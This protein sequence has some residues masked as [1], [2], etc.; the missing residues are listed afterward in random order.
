MPTKA[1][2]RAA[3]RE[4][5]RHDFTGARTS[6]TELFRHLGIARRSG[7]RTLLTEFLNSSDRTFHNQPNIEET[8]GRPKAITNEAL[9]TMGT[10]LRNSDVQTRAMTWE[11][12]GYEAGLHVSPRTIQRAMGSLDYHKCIACRKGWVSPELG[13]RRKD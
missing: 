12:L 13:I 4:L 7:N 11:T 3:Y 9:R 6:K 1:R 10:I 5:K 8:R 2:V